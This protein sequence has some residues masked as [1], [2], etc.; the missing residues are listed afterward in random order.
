V[1]EINK[2]IS[3]YERA[4]LSDLLGYSSGILAKVFRYFAKRYFV[5]QRFFDEDS[6]LGCKMFLIPRY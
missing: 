3:G 2:I 6:V 5:V 4:M 1:V